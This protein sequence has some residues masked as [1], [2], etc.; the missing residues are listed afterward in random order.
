[1][2]SGPAIRSYLSM[3]ESSGKPPAFHLDA[4][5]RFFAALGAS[6]IAVVFTPWQWHW[7]TRVL[8][9]W[10][11]YS[12]CVLVLAWITLANEEPGEV[13]RTARLQDSGRTAIFVFAIVAACASVFAV[14][15]ELGTA[16]GLDTARFSGHIVFCLVTVLTSWLLVHTVFAL[17]YAHIYYECGENGEPKRGLNFPDEETPDYLDFAYFSF[18]IGMTSQVSDVSISGQRLRRLA[19]LHGLISFAFNLSILGLCINII[20]GLF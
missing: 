18:V 9:A 14:A 19:L 4:H 8:V 2:V 10:N 6:A 11:A 5:H 20:S 15:A 1:M 3:G 16:K 13:A 12:V 17:R 7:T